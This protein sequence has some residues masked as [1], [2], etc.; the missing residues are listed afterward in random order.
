[1]KKTTLLFIVLLVAQASVALGQYVNIDTTRVPSASFVRLFPL[2][3]L[4]REFR[5]G[6]EV[7]TAPRQAFIIDGSYFW[8]T[9]VAEKSDNKSGWA[10][11]M[12][13]RF[14]SRD[15]S[16]GS[17]F[18]I[19]PNLML[20]QQE[21]TQFKTNGRPVSDMR[22]V[23]CGNLKVGSDFRLG[24]GV[25]PRLEFVTGIGFRYQSIGENLSLAGKGGSNSNAG[26]V[27]PNVLFGLVLKL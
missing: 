7:A 16:A 27:L 10:L 18:F 19:G 4:T 8:G 15:I 5:L 2:E 1:M 3:L 21:V 11:K 6:F 12:D 25:G 22:T 13:Y 17:R 20:K 23:F 26:S 9:S 14:Y 24:S